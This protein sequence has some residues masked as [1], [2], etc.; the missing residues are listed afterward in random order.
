MDDW[1]C[2]ERE[3]E[4]GLLSDIVFTII[5]IVNTKIHFIF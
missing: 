5:K 4:R 3:R 2:T 1:F